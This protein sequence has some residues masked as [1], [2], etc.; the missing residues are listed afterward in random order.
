MALRKK[1]M[2]EKHAVKLLKKTINYLKQQM[3]INLEDR[4]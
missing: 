2:A 4:N 3:D 1:T